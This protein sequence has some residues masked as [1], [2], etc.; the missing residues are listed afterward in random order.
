MIY[1]TLKAPRQTETLIQVFGGIDKTDACP[2][3]CLSD[4]QNTSSHRYPL[5]STR[6][7]RLTLARLAEPPSAIHTVG[8]ITLTL[9]T[10]LFHNGVLQ[11]DRLA[12]GSKKQL[13]SMGGKTIVF[14]D[15]YYINTTDIDQNGICTD[16]GYIFPRL[17]LESGFIGLFPCVPDEPIP[18]NGEEPPEDPSDGDYWLDSSVSPND[19]KKYSEKKGDWVSVT[20]THTGIYLATGYKQFAVGTPIFISGTGTNADGL[21]SVTH[22]R[23]NILVIDKPITDYAVLYPEKQS[24][25]CL[26]QPMPVMDAVCEQG[27]RLWGCRYGTDLNGGFVNEIYASALGEPGQFYKFEGLSTDSYAASCGSDGPFTGIISHMGYVVF[28]KE[29]KIHRLF[30]TKPANFTLYE[31]AFTG[32]K[33]GCEGSLCLKD[34]VVYYL[35]ADGFYAYT[36][37]SPSRISDPLGNIQLT[38]A[39]AAFVKDTYTVCA[40]GADGRRVVY[41][42]NTDR[43]LWHF[44][45]NTSFVTLASADSNALG[46][47]D[48]IGNYSLCLLDGTEIPPDV[49]EVYGNGIESESRIEW[50]AESPF[51]TVN[52][53]DAKTLRRLQIR[54]D[55]DEDSRVTL[56]CKTDNSPSWEEW[57]TVSG[58]LTTHTLHMSLPRCDRVKIRLEGSGGCT[59]YGITKIFEYG[60]EVI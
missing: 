27:N 20:P 19:L 48:N 43:G 21:H 42:Y 18:E 22:T 53:L 47:T 46:V 31:D 10:S 7:P 25:V 39:I 11:Y 40:D 49:K 5:L 44:H 26:H 12:E 23:K 9:G 55:A 36:G 6:K 51:L 1:P 28:F 8:G 13:V 15:G 52:T 58:G 54:R 57:G 41:A 35:G 37:S 59:L 32:V 14:P 2:E 38:D 33:Q 16:Q 4:G 17:L 60:G 30:G 29:N 3:N 24:S 34:G 45:G 56:L 50:F